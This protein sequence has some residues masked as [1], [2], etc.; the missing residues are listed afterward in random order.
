M[1]NSQVLISEL[2]WN[3][4]GFYTLGPTPREVDPTYDQIPLR[5]EWEIVSQIRG[6][7]LPAVSKSRIEIRNKYLYQVLF[8]NLCFAVTILRIEIPYWFGVLNTET[9]PPSIK[10]GGS[11]LHSRYT[12]NPF[13]LP[14][15]ST[16]LWERVCEHLVKFDGRPTTVLWRPSG[17]PS[18]H[19]ETNTDQPQALGEA[20]NLS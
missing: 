12:S 3:L 8:R 17:E 1:H 6:N 10:G 15:C 20:A 19:W 7:S 11:L 14:S 4:E 16:I 5:D 18:K 13:I 2:C 9:P